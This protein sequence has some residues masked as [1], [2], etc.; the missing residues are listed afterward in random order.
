MAIANRSGVQC[1]GR[2]MKF[3]KAEVILVCGDVAMLILAIG[4]F[5]FP[6]LVD[7]RKELWGVFMGWNAALMLALKTDSAPQSAPPPNV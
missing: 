7:L 6:Q 2:L 1:E 3:T 4:S 5:F